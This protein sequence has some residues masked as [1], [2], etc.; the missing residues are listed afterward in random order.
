MSSCLRAACRPSFSGPEDVAGLFALFLSPISGKQA[1]GL[2]IWDA[3]DYGVPRNQ[4]PLTYLH[5]QGS[6]QGVGE[7][8][9]SKAAGLPIDWKVDSRATHLHEGMKI[10]STRDDD[11]CAEAGESS[12]TCSLSPCVFVCFCLAH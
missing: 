1:A 4:S 12:W 10:S 7:E 3:E 8:A 6:A 5:G 9:F 2:A 11:H